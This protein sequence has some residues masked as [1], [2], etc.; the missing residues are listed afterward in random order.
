MAPPLG[1]PTFQDE[2]P[3]FYRIG[4]ILYLL[5]RSRITR[6]VILP[7]ILLIALVYGF[8]A[9][10]D[11]LL[12]RK[13]KRV[14]RELAQL[15][16]SVNQFKDKMGHYPDSLDEL[17]QA[18]IVTKLPRDPFSKTKESYK[19]I[20][21]NDGAMVRV[22]SAGEDGMDNHSIK[23]IVQVAH[24]EVYYGEKGKG[25][26][27]TLQIEWT[28]DD[29]NN[30]MSDFMRG[31][32]ASKLE[33]INPALEKLKYIPE[34]GWNETLEYMDKGRDYIK[35][36]GKAYPIPGIPLDFASFPYDI[37][38][39]SLIDVID[40]FRENQT[41]F[42]LIKQ[43]ASKP[44]TKSVMPEQDISFTTPIPN[45]LQ[46]Q[47][48]SKTLISQGKWLESQGKLK[49]AM[50]DYLVV[51]HLGQA[52]GCNGTMIGKLID[53]ALERMAYR[54][55]IEAASKYEFKPEY[56]TSLIERIENLEQTAPLMT[57]AYHSE[58]LCFVSAMDEFKLFS[59]N[60]IFGKEQN[61]GNRITTFYFVL[62]K[63]KMK[64]NN[65]VFWDRMTEY[66]QKPYPESATADINALISGMDV[67]NRIAAPNFLNANVRD[68]FCRSH[69]AAAKIILGLR[70]YHSLHGEYP[71]TLED[72]ADLYE[73][74]PVDP[75]TTEPFI[76]EK[77]GGSFRLYSPGP[78][79]V[80]DKA[81]F[82]YDPT[83]GT[84]SNGDILY[85][86]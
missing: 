5:Y 36:Y 14:E 79:L 4:R 6:F 37:T 1:K 15:V 69:S 45:F 58:H 23:D 16:E 22:Y 53:V 65:A 7:V 86:Q 43:G 82:E 3:T 50:D 67:L 25:L 66:A 44:Y 41:A 8:F 77:I 13:H 72:I 2:F 26:Y 29:P 63:E 80:D 19:L 60:S 42:D 61:V 21:L 76:Y 27:E 38:S 59:R 85:G 70:H 75:F 81:A 35:N 33:T 31:M 68:V 18:G 9:L 73:T 17:I 28:K 39:A 71:D 10:S 84:V 34:Y 83:N 62:T 54:A 40:L 11:A 12:A 30:G 74:P 48:L 49:D 24:E 57:D 78:E 47:L 20:N 56:L 52:M 46:S 32:L 64:Q 51:V 55:I